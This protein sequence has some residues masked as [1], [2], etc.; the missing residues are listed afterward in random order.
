MRG[1]PAD[2][3]VKHL[4]VA[5]PNPALSA[6]LKRDY[7]ERLAF[8]GCR[9]FHCA[10]THLLESP[11]DVLVTNLR[12]V[13]YNG[14]H[15]VL[16][17]QAANPRTRCIVHTDRPDLLLI[18]EAQANGAFFEYTARLP[19]SLAGYLDARLPDRDRRDPERVDRRI[20]VRGG[21]RTAD[22]AALV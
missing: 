22:H 3:T 10:R 2:T 19:H 1:A 16:L 15:L 18:R 17:A 13:D 21:R 5:E 6:S 14:L 7:G 9:D 8:V 11:P 4:L 20:A 12:L